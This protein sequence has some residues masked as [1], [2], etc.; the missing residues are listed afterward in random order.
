MFHQGIHDCLKKNATKYMNQA[1]TKLLN[2]QKQV[3]IFHLGEDVMVHESLCVS[4]KKS[5][6]QG[7]YKYIGTIC[8]IN[9]E[10]KFFKVVWKS[11]HPSSEK[12][13]HESQKK[14]QKYQILKFK[15]GSFTLLL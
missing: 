2:R 10:H 3:E 12:L 9:P 13:G 8:W 14:Y 11:P 4:M 6:N 1:A 15:E 7:I 5:L